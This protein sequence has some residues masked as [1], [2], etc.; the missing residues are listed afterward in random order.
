MTRTIPSLRTLTLAGIAAAACLLPASAAPPEH[1]VVAP[2]RYV[3]SIWDVVHD[4][5]EV[6]VVKRELGRA[7]F[8]PPTEQGGVLP[9]EWFGPIAVVKHVDHVS[10][11]G[12]F[13][14]EDGVVEDTMYEVEVR[15]DQVLGP[16]RESVQPVEISFRLVKRPP[17]FQPPPPT[18]R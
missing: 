6:V 5:G 12:A 14:R 1:G 4:A 9:G 15:Q 13:R 7:S 8:P 17:H 10:W 2:P 11:A 16:I 3:V 18:T